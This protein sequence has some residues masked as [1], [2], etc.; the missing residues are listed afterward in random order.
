MD[1]LLSVSIA[2]VRGPQLKDI[3]LKQFKRMLA[4]IFFLIFL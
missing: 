4:Y 3:Q 1:K 2:V